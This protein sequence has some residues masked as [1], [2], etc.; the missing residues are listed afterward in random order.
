[1][2]SICPPISSPLE[3]SVGVASEAGGGAGDSGAC[4]DMLD[5]RREGGGAHVSKTAEGVCWQNKMQW[6]RRGAGGGG[7]GDMNGIAAAGRRGRRGGMKCL[8]I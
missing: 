5:V 6:V 1:M 7:G 2:T 4:D 8:R 3:S